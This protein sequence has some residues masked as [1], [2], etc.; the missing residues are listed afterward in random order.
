MLHAWAASSIAAV[1]PPSPEWQHKALQHHSYALQDLGRGIEAADETA[2]VDVVLSDEWKRATVLILHIFE[3]GIPVK[4]S[5]VSETDPTQSFSVEYGNVEL[6]TAHLHAAHRIFAV[7]LIRDV[8]PTRHDLLLLEA[9]ILRTALNCLPEAGTPLPLDYMSFLLRHFK[10]GLSEFRLE[11]SVGDCPWIGYL[12]ND[13][14]DKMY[15]LSWLAHKLPLR[16]ER[17]AEGIAIS[18]FFAEWTEPSAYY[19]DAE[20]CARSEYHIQ[21]R[22]LLR[23]HVI[24]CRLLSRMVLASD[25]NMEVLQEYE[26]LNESVALLD[27]VCER[28]E[29]TASVLWPLLIFS[30]LI[31]TQFE[32]ETCQMIASRAVRCAGPGVV[33]HLLALQEDIFALRTSSGC[34]L[35]SDVLQLVTSRSV[36]L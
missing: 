26:K 19:A 12:G 8:P 32:L 30:M 14:L 36:F 9:Y 28:V 31:S 7:S 34:I 2:A 21:A 20:D 24:A 18:R 29:M 3:V 4:A 11:F 27:K 13:L 5:D 10:S 6:A 23:A 1:A 16:S 15:R 33:K 17:L 35:V 25:A 22:R